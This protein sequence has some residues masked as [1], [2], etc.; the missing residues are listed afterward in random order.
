MCPF[1]IQLHYTWLIT[2]PLIIWSFEQLLLRSFINTNKTII[3]LWS[4]CGALLYFLSIFFHELGH[5]IA[6]KVFR[7]SASPRVLFP[8]GSVEPDELLSPLEKQGVL[9]ALAGPIMS[10]VLAICLYLLL[11]LVN[12]INFHSPLAL[13][14]NHFILINFLIVTINILPFYPLDCGTVFRFMLLKLNKHPLFSIQIIT[15]IGIIVSVITFSSG[16]LSLYNGHFFIGIWCIILGFLFKSAL[17]IAIRKRNLFL[18]INGEKVSSYMR[19]NPITIHPSLALDKFILDYYYRFHEEIYPVIQFSS[20]QGIITS[21]SIKK[22]PREMWKHYTV[23]EV[24]EPLSNSNSVSSEN[25]IIEVLPKLG[26]F[27]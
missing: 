27:A 2:F 6:A 11:L 25:D 13:L 19:L 5:I 9:V 18:N 26:R 10:S 17:D 20:V 4:C 8:F 3:I 16:F 24:A 1:P 15:Y 14:L 23:G 7:T 21:Q 22:I 12:L